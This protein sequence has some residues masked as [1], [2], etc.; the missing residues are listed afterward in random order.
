MYSKKIFYHIILSLYLFGCAVQGP[1]S[2][3][4]IDEEPPKLVSVYP[5]N[6]STKISKDENIILDFDELIDPISVYNSIR[7]NNQDF[8]IKVKGKKIILYPSNDWNPDFLVDIYINRELSDYQKNTIENPLNLFY[9]LS[10]KISTNNISGK[11]IDI[12]NVMNKYNGES[13]KTFFEVGL[14]KI[15]DSGKKLVK[16]VD[17]NKDLGFRF[18]A[19]EDGYYSIA[20][21]ENKLIDINL[22]LSKRRYA[23]LDSIYVSSNN[24]D[25]ILKMNIA[26]PIFKKEISSINFINQYYVNYM[27]SDNSIEF[28]I[29]DTIYNNF[30]QSDFSG[31]L[32][33]T[34]LI[35]ENEF[36]S[37]STNIF[38]FIVPEVVDTIAPIIHSINI[39]ELK[40]S[41]LFSEPLERFNDERIFYIVKD[42]NKV[43]ID[44]KFGD[45][46]FNNVINISLE[47]FVEYNMSS[48]FNIN[49][50]KNI[51]KDLYGN[52]FLDSLAIID[53]GN[54]RI[55]NKYIGTSK[56]SGIISY[57]KKATPLSVA[58]YNLETLER[59]IVLA[60]KNYNFIFD[61]VLPGEYLLQC[62][63]NY[64]LN[65]EIAYPYFGGKW[66][67][68]SKTLHF[69]DIIGPIEA[70]ANWDIENITIELNKVIE[71][72]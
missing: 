5:E 64:D 56:V 57:N 46:S 42:S 71:N 38:E 11:I 45:L 55:E 61:G 41:L 70:R 60:D 31:E 32:M 65:S 35:L 14:F 17:S 19:I 37:Y 36:E 59:I 21:I 20:A 8:K 6:F 43:Y 15:L 54:Q 33:R 50:E 69:S 39:D 52:I 23:L 51:I 63:E 25:I 3:G 29:I 72:E 30:N 28:G 7:I 9:S 66:N 18:D 13:N 16:K 24:E 67:S 44:Y 62:Y 68:N 26:D 49:I 10:E 47:Q 58:L 40:F 2:G 4:P 22:D 1:I 53:L 34:S 48:S 27:L 12:K